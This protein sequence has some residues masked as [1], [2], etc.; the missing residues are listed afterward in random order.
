MK[1]SK[2]INDN[3]MTAWIFEDGIEVYES[4]YDYDLYCFRVYNGDVLLGTIY[5][6][7]IE[8]MNCCI[9]ALDDGSNPIADGWEDGLGNA[10]T[11]DGWGNEEN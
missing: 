3:G 8:N 9:K 5:P 10:C 11:L 1:F 7:T 4:S 2:T 6:D